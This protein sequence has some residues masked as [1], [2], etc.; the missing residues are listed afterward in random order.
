M[1]LL[2]KLR[3]D[4][5]D[6]LQMVNLTYPQKVEGV[7]NEL[8]NLETIGDMKYRTFADLRALTGAYVMS[9]YEFFNL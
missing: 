9:P 8:E 1:T 6:K 2:D 4:Y 7:V 5:S 3:E